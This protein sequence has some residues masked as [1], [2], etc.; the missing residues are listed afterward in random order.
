MNQAEI[1]G[2]AYTLKAL[3]NQP[4]LSKSAAQWFSEKWN[5][6]A[7]A[8]EESISHCIK[9]DKTVPQW[10]VVLDEKS[11][12][13]AGAGVIKNDF[14]NRKDLSPNLCALYVEQKHRRQGIAL[15]LLNEVRQDLKNMGVRRLYLVTD[16]TNFYEKCGWEFLTMVQDEEGQPER[17]YTVFTR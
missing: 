11:E 3:R 6:P 10:Y 13:A 2:G 1:R 15:C 8:Y 17:M 5:I 7:A 4:E 14:H 16:H 9:G 12:I